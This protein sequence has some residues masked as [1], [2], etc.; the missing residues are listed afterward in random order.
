MRLRHYMCVLLFV[1]LCSAPAVTWAQTHSEVING[2][3]CIPYP[4]F[5]R[6]N[7]IPYQHYLFAF[8]QSAFC[9]LTMSNDW[10]VTDLRYVLFS[11]NTSGGPISARLCLHDSFRSITCG[12]VS[13]L[14]SFPVNWVA[15]PSPV[16]SY[17][18]GGYVAFSFPSGTVS[19]IYELIPVW[20]K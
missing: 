11:G 15:P 16:P 6:S 18:T 10:T 12:A 4:P 1:A 2:A 14:T 17:S 19:L 8:R 20:S 3:T 7:A 13:T 9:H 5:E